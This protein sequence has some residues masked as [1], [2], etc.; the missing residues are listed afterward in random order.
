M[1]K[2]D[3]IVTKTV[4]AELSG[5]LDKAVSTL[6][7]DTIS[8]SHIK[9]LIEDERVLVNGR[10]VKASFKVKA[11]DEI[12][13]IIPPVEETEIKA[14]NIPL[15]I[16]YEDDDVILVNKP[17]GMVVHPAAGHTSGTLVNA[18]MYHC[19]EDLSGIN[20]ELRPGIVHRIDKDTTGV[21]IACKNDNA[22]RKIAEQLAVHSITR[23]YHALVYNCIKE[24]NGTIDAP[25]GR[26]P[27]DRK[28]MAINRQYG[29]NAVT[30]YE[31]IENFHV[32]NSNGYS[33][34]ICRL[35]TGRTHQIRVHMTSIGH[36]LLG[37]EVY[38]PQ[39]NPFHLEGQALHAEVLGFVHPT[40][41]KYMEF[42]APLPDY[43]NELICK[44][45]NL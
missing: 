24:E 33:H 38:G 19:G 2:E 1:N 36:P 27:T 14:E 17:K 45:K 9:S 21:I 29:K 37:D 28:K 13:I 6:M 31:V 44:L 40:T 4:P 20:G 39:K 5:R 30:H 25:I 42:H 8:R 11:D 22:H 43:F 12:K 18:L 32:R 10:A 41:G 35:E 23:R 7:L 15:D 34:V 26:H 16:I 3:T